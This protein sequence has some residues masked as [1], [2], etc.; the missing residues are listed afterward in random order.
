MLTKTAASTA[1]L[2][3]LSA[4]VA[5]DPEST[6][7]TRG[8][9][10]ES[11]AREGQKQNANAHTWWELPQDDLWNVEGA[12]GV[13]QFPGD[14]SKYFW[15]W[16]YN[17]DNGDGTYIGLQTTGGPRMAIFSI[18]NAV[19]ADG[20]ACV[21]FGGEGDGLSCRLPFNFEP[22]HVYRTRIRSLSD[23]WW[24]GSIIDANTLEEYPIGSIRTRP[25]VSGIQ[26]WA[27]SFT[28]Y[29]GD[30]V[31][32]S[33]IGIA[34][35]WFERPLANDGSLS[36]TPVGNAAGPACFGLSTN[37]SPEWSWQRYGCPT[38]DCG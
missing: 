14:E 37:P 2:A 5:C 28:E 33:D 35:A 16:F 34:G 7:M 10:P 26:G 18:W 25:G 9:E 3:M 38:A 6:S 11:I 24:A 17:F 15:A 21:A 19:E 8:I 30:D 32:C 31:P 13:E 1:L 27:V 12:I 4:G 20:P 23:D 22:G 29:Y 36:G